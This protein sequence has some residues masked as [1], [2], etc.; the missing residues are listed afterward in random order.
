MLYLERILPESFRDYLYGEFLEL[1]VQKDEPQAAAGGGGPGDAPGTACKARMLNAAGE[2]PEE[3][4]Q[5][6]MAHGDV[7]ASGLAPPPPRAAKSNGFLQDYALSKAELGRLKSNAFPRQLHNVMSK[8]DVDVVNAFV[9]A[10]PWG[11]EACW[12][13]PAGHKQRLG[14]SCVRKTRT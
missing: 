1:R 7:V 11:A 13:F 2:M 4:P 12:W 9:G 3:I 5:S 6:S 10:G 14:E 8:L